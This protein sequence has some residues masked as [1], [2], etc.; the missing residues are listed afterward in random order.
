MRHP[1]QNKFESVLEK[2]RSKYVK[3]YVV[4]WDYQKK[5][6]K[7]GVKYESDLPED[8]YT[9]KGPQEI[10]GW[11]NWFKG[12][13]PSFYK[14]E[15]IDP[16]YE[17]SLQNVKAILKKLDVIYDF[18][19]YKNV[20]L[21]NAHDFFIPQSYPVPA[22][23][24]IKT[25]LDFGAGYGR[26][27]NL[28]WPHIKGKGN[29]I[30]VDAIPMSYGLQNSYY[31][32]IKP[33]F[34]DYIENPDSFKIDTKGSDLYHVPTWRL[35]LI[36][37][38]SVD[39]ILCVQVLPELGKQLIH[40]IF[41]QFQRILKP[42]GAFY[43]RDLNY[44]YKT[45]GA[46]DIDKSLINTGFTLEYKA[47]IEHNKHLHGIPKIWRKNIDSITNLQK[48]SLAQKKRYLLEDIDALTGG[49]LKK[50]KK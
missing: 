23:F 31:R 17:Q 35:D 29:F 45:I 49:I 27:A 46:I 20:G 19:N 10:V 37:D 21:N 36:P 1:F 5:R 34:K 40:Y 3:P 2:D 42:G 18:A 28:W 22:E 33:D 8:F 43:I 44:M 9:Y 16:L 39:L 15:V 7:R 14:K 13:Y 25:V 50:K 4:E 38:N 47:F 30:A 12:E 24:E 32:S 6:K 11:M 26:Q 48:N 41:E